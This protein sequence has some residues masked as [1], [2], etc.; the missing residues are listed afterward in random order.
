MLLLGGVLGIHLGLIGI[1]VYATIVAGEWFL[2]YEHRPINLHYKSNSLSLA[3]YKTPRKP[4][5]QQKSTFQHLHIHS[6]T[7]SYIYL[8]EIATIIRITGE[9]NTEK[10]I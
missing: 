5:H 10:Y 4:Y 6:H 8:H 3:D 7:L 1:P 9:I 2:N